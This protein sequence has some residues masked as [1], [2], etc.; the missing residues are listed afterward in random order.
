MEIGILL[1]LNLQKAAK[2]MVGPL[3]GKA[4]ERFDEAVNSILQSPLKSFS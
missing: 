3:D 1:I 2:E 4:S